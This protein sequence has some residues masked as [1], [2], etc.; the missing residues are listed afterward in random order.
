M[1]ARSNLSPL[2]LTAQCQQTLESRTSPVDCKRCISPTPQQHS[3][4]IMLVIKLISSSWIL[5]S[6]YSMNR[7]RGNAGVESWW[8]I[9]RATILAFRYETFAVFLVY[10]CELNKI[11]FIQ[12]WQIFMYKNNEE[13]ILSWLLP[14]KIV[15]RP[16]SQLEQVRSDVG[17]SKAQ[18]HHAEIWRILSQILFSENQLENYK[19]LKRVY[20]ICM[21][22][23]WAKV[24]PATIMA[25]FIG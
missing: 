19:L 22:L 24:R 13:H 8:K 21:H 10:S 15:H 7:K 5:K 3:V 17:E 4:S 1:S 11:E 6:I 16:I 2:S 12:I 14:R 9:K 20:E 23:V 18:V 25:I